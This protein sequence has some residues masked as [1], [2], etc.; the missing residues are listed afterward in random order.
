MKIEIEIVRHAGASRPFY[1]SAVVKNVRRLK[2]SSVNVALFNRETTN[3]LQAKAGKDSAAFAIPPGG[4]LEIGIAPSKPKKRK[5]TQS[6][7]ADL[8]ATVIGIK[9][10]NRYV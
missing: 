10:F 5:R 7:I 3:G 6:M 9:Q 1:G 4:R 2:L 8:P